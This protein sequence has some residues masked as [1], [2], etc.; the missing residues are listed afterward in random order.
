MELLLDFSLWKYWYGSLWRLSTKAGAAQRARTSPSTLV[1]TSSEKPSR[2][3]CCATF[4]PSH[5]LQKVLT[6]LLKRLS[7]LMRYET[8]QLLVEIILDLKGDKRAY[9]LAKTSKMNYLVPVPKNQ[10]QLS[11]VDCIYF[12]MWMFNNH[13]ARNQFKVKQIKNYEKQTRVGNLGSSEDAEI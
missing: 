5:S 6:I 9:Q 1:Q 11:P 8:W 10:E 2:H 7:F 3:C 4:S 12:S 13:R